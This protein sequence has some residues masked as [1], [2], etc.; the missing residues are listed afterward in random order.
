MAVLLIEIIC[1]IFKCKK[2][3]LS[4]KLRCPFNREK[5]DSLFGELLL[6]TTYKNRQG[7]K[8]MLRY[9]ALSIQDANHL[10]AYNGFLGVTV[11]QHFYI[12]HR[13]QL[14]HY[15]LPCV[16]EYTRGGVHYFPLELLELVLPIC[17]CWNNAEKDKCQRNR[18]TKNDNTTL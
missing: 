11:A 17:L 6:Q 10:K 4:E 8:H 2:D 9:S 13:I 15:D 5:L 1:K 16:A 7:L 18:R 3:E 14:Q 12:R